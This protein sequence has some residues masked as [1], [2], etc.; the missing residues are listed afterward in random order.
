VKKK[1]ID[2]IKSSNYLE[3]DII[4]ELTEIPGGIVISFVILV[5]LILLS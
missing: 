5:V 2:Y 1:Y 3:Y 4:G